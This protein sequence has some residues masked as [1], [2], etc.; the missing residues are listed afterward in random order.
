MTGHPHFHRR[1]IPI[2]IRGA[3]LSFL[4]TDFL[5]KKG[6]NTGIVDFAKMRV[7]YG[8]TGNDADLYYVYDRFVAASSSNPGYPNVDDLTFR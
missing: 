5:E 7:A 4:L 3:T 1:I 2:S 8:M 6:V